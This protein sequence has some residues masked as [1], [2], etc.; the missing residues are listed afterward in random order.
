ML[1]REEIQALIVHRVFACCASCNSHHI[2]T[3]IGQIRGL[4]A[5]LN[6]GETILGH[7]ADFA[8]NVLEAAGVPHT[9]DGNGWQV[10]D[11]WMLAAG[12]R[13]DSLA[14][15]STPSHPKFKNF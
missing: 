7:E 11:E 1:T 8:W 10:P 3:V 15:G 6:D 2:T 4:L 12:F 13:P 9:R 5:V 14:E